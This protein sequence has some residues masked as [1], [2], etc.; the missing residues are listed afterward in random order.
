MANSISNFVINIEFNYRICWKL[1][2]LPIYLYFILMKI[3]SNP[4]LTVLSIIFGL[5]VFNYFLD[6]KIIFYLSIIISGIGVFSSKT[7]LIL[8][9]IWFKISYILSQ[10][11]P[12]ILLFLL[13]FLILT[14]LSFLSKIFRA[15]SGFNLKKNQITMFV[16]LNKKFNKDSF[17]RAW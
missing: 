7:S 12:N 3:K 10:I 9:K 1:S 13:F 14:P 11:I 6:N 8:E 2:T 4:S 16:K 17:K 15:K 5:L